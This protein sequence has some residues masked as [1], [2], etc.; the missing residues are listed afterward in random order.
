MLHVH[1][2]AYLIAH[3]F[4]LVQ[5]LPHALLALA[6]EG[7][8]A[9]LLDL[10][11]AVQTQQLFDLQLH[12]QAMG[13]PAG[14]TGHVLALHGPEAGEQILNDAGLDVADM[15]L[16]VG[17]W[18]A[19]KESEVLLAV[20]AQGEGLMHDVLVLPQLRHV[21][22]TGNEI[23]VCRNLVVHGV[24]LLCQCLADCLLR[25]VFPIKKRPRTFLG[26][27]LSIRGTTQ[28]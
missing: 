23:Q 16:A 18:R 8:N 5:I 15:R 10:R 28:G 25:D 22:L 4:P 1:P 14:L 17:R 11:L 27:M 19:I 6:D 24:N 9:V 2:V 7:L 21:L 3:L 13:V 20:V 12:G 26:R